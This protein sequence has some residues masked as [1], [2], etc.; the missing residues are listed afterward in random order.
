MLICITLFKVFRKGVHNMEILM[1]RHDLP[2][3]WITFALPRLFS[4]R[5]SCPWVN[6][7]AD[8]ATSI[9][10]SIELK[11]LLAFPEA[12]WSFLIKVKRF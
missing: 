9:T 7:F 4:K 11:V 6:E 12:D 5:Q 8:L 2:S 10:L 1:S 3:A